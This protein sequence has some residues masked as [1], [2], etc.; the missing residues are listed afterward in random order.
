MFK[1][2][3]PIISVDNDVIL[4][5]SGNLNGRDNKLV[6]SEWH[7]EVLSLDNGDKGICEY[8]IV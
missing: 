4:L 2:P 1:M 6:L 5:G 7:C 8:N 3:L